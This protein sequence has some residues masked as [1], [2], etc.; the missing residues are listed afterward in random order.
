MSWSG[1]RP[2]T[3]DELPFIGQIPHWKNAFIAAG[4]FRAGVQLS[5][6]TAQLITEMLT[7]QPTCVDASAFRLDRKLATTARPTF[8]S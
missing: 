5:I 2:G 1:L 4:H 3:R 6:G 7:H 8:R